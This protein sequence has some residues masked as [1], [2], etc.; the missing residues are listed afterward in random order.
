MLAQP[1]LLRELKGNSNYA[2]SRPGAGRRQ[3]VKSTPAAIQA[4]LP[5]ALSTLAAQQDF[6]HGEVSQGPLTAIFYHPLPNPTLV[7]RFSAL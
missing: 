3:I 1:H 7:S 5:P 4:A 2:R 6:S